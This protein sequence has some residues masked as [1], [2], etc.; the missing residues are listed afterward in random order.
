MPAARRFMRS[1]ARAKREGAWEG[2]YVPAGDVVAGTGVGTYLWSDIS[3]Q[4][5]NAPERFLHRVTY[6]S[7]QVRPTPS[8]GN[9]GAYF[10]LGW[11]VMHVSTDVTN[12]VPATLLWSPLSTATAVQR[13]SILARGFFGGVMPNY[14]VAQGGQPDF[15][16][17]NLEIKAR[18]KMSNEDALVLVLES[19]LTMADQVDVSART[20]CS[21]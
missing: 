3:S 13:K 5:L 4:D 1:R 21:W 14:T 2:V 19:T 17:S 15:G 10:K 12:S 8:V 20:Y 18:R 16:F 9:Y 7:I 11:Y 6:L